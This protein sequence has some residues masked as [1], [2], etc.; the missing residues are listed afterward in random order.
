MFLASIWTQTEITW[1]T[2]CKIISSIHSAMY[3]HSNDTLK[4][5]G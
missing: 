1:K 4:E 3:C 5:T 2:F